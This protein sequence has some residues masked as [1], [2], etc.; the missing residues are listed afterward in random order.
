[1]DPA[2]E[3]P[4]WTRPEPPASSRRSGRGHASARRRRSAAGSGGLDARRDSRRIAARA[5]R[6][7]DGQRRRSS[8]S[9]STRTPSTAWSSE[10]WAQ[11]ARRHR[12]QARPGARAARPARAPG[13]LRRRPARARGREHARRGRPRRRARAAARST[14]LDRAAGQFGFSTRSCST[15][16]GRVARRAPGRSGDGADARRAGRAAPRSRSA[17]AAATMR[18]G[19]DG[20]PIVVAVALVA[21]RRRPTGAG[22]WCSASAIDRE[23]LRPL[24]DDWPGSGAGA[25]APT[26]CARDGDDVD[27]PDA[28]RR[29]RP[30]RRPARAA[31]RSAR[32]GAA[33]MAATGVESNVEVADDRGRPR[34]GPPR[35]TCRSSAGA[36]SAR[37]TA[38]RCSAGMRGTLVGL[39]AARPRAGRWSR[40]L[41]AWF[42]RRQYAR[43]L[44]R[45]RDRASPSRHAARVQAVFD[46]AFDAILTFDRGGRVRT[47]N[48]AAEQLFGRPPTRARG[49]PLHRFLRWGE[50]GA[51]RPSDAA[52][53]RA[54]CARRGDARRRRRRSRS[55]SRSAA[56]GEGDGAALH[57][58]RARHQRARRGRAAHPR[59]RRGARGQQPPARGGERPARGGVA[60]QERVPGQHLARAAHAAQRHDRVP[61]AGAR[62]HVRLAATRSATSCSRRCSARATCSGLINDVLDIA[63]IEAGKLTLEIERGRRARSCS[64]RSTPSPTCRPQQKGLDAARSSRR[65]TRRRG[66]RRLRQDQAGADQPGRQQPQV[67][68]QGQ[69]H[70]ARAA[71]SPT[72]GHVMFEVRRHRHRHPARPPEADLRE[73]HAGRRQHHAPL[74]R[75]RARARDLAQPGRADGRHHRRRRA[76]ARARARAC[77]SRCRSGATRRA[78]LPTPTS[79]PREPIEGPAGGALVLVVEDDSGVPHAS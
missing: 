57:R 72:S 47:V 26:W 11:L 6:A 42:W 7:R 64:T 45:A 44:A 17:G 54:W 23:A 65:P 55:S 33:A 32:T 73:V 25:P 58:D 50:A 20:E 10:R 60:A 70:G 38:R 35:A 69:H 34:A 78:T 52:A 71:R 30:A 53:R 36:S 27:A 46:T 15:P 74:R 68:A 40:S 13:A 77:T 16:D 67:H 28:A 29:A 62:R 66:A 51:R 5:D 14:E 24:L 31:H 12:R 19:R 56:P 18:I 79:A 21:G 39:L 76:R 41:A 2:S 59:L 8:T 3:Q 49:Q 63:K 48:R 43:G 9:G 75:H 4:S 61:A 1:M 22:R 37:S